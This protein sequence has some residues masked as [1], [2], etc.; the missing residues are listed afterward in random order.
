[1]SR[2][3][4]VVDGPNAVTAAPLSLSDAGLKERQDLQEW[5]IAH[6]QVLGDDVLVVTAEFDQWS[7]DAGSVAKER[8]D[9]LGLDAS[10]RLV[11][12]ELK[13]DGDPRIHLQAITYAALVSGF[14][15]D[16]LASVH[17]DFLTRRGTPVTHPEALARLRDHVEGELDGDVLAV[18]RIVLLAGHHPAQVVTSA[19][20][21]TRQGIDVELRQV[22]A[23][24]FGDQV[25]VTFD[26]VYPVPGVDSLLLA[27]ARKQTVEAVK[28]ADEQAR[29]ASAARLIVEGELLPA[30]AVL[31]LHPTVEVPAEVRGIVDA[32]VDEAPARG[33][34][35][36][37]NDPVRP[38]RWEVDGQLWRPT[39][40]VRHII[41]EAAGLDRGVRGTA[42][43]VT[44]DGLDLTAVAGISGHNGGR[45][46]SDVHA[47]IAL[48]APGEW[49]SYGDIGTVVGLPARPVGTHISRCPSCPIGA[50][51]VLTADGTP[52]DSFRWEDAN[53]TRT[54]GEVL[55][56]EGLPLDAAGRADAIRR[57]T[58]GE[59]KARLKS[60]S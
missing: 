52:S 21:L 18:P 40:L 30:G 34:A 57:V 26:Q 13:R 45:D 37:V 55:A 44:E 27:P 56:A 4:F 11:V 7:S 29:S 16:T 60:G 17:A 51:R 24:K 22:Q 49:T 6:P 39:T 23:F 8:L 5:V 42:W 47:L 20:W 32:W 19:V 3:V 31:S 2:H 25:A 35:T 36:W 28:K 54:V 9:V 50:W 46:W 38:L 33:R 10:G 58:A 1:M 14:D 15:E 59:L 43:W 41:K 53:D 48:V 12:V